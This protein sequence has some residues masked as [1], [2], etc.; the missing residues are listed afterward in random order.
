MTPAGFTI[1]VSCVLYVARYHLQ[2]CSRLMLHSFFPDW[3]TATVSCLDFLLTSSS[4]S[5]L[6]RTL[7][8]S[9]NFHNSTVRTHCSCGPLQCSSAF[10]GCASQNVSTSNC[11]SV[12][13]HRSIHGTSTSYLQLCFTRVSDMTS[14]QRLRSST[15][16]RLDVPPVR[17][18]TVGRR[19][20]PVSGAAV[21]NDLPLNVASAPS[22]AVFRQRLHD[23]SVF[24][25]LPRHYHM[26]RVLLSPFITTVWTPVVLAIIN[27]I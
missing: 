8:G 9:A 16:D 4:V 23:L 22:L 25:F 24:P 26:T 15:S 18:S 6:F 7:C 19:A 27:I 11:L 14:R 12:M 17:L 5:N 10:T 13:T 3:I 1:S 2:C 21:W 20:L